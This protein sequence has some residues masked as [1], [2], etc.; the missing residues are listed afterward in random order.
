MKKISKITLE[1][2]RAFA[3]KNVVDFNNSE[4]KPA[5]LICIYGKNGSGKTSMFDGFE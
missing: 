2:F 1:N 3:G 5:D 4:N